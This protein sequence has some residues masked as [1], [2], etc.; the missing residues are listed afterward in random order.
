MQAALDGHSNSLDWRIAEGDSGGFDGGSEQTIQGMGLNVA[1]PSESKPLP[2]KVDSEAETQRFGQRAPV[3]RRME[4]VLTSINSHVSAQ[5][6][7]E[8]E[9]LD[10]LSKRR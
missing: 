9:T 5:A 2:P 3:R 10:D 6:T 1:A 8:L 4:L 7:S